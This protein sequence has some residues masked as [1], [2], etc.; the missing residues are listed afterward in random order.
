MSKS[1]FFNLALKRGANWTV[2]RLSIQGFIAQIIIG[3]ACSVVALAITLVFRELMENTL[4]LM[5]LFTIVV[6]S[7]LGGMI[8]G[9]ASSLISVFLIDYSALNPE[10]NLVQSILFLL[11]AV[12][13]SWMQDRRL[14]AEQLSKSLIEQRDAILESV[15]DGITA[16][17]PNGEVVF[18]NQA[19]AVIAGYAN[20]TDILEPIEQMQ[21]RYEM[22]DLN[23]SPLSFSALP[24]NTVFKEGKS[25]ELIFRAKM[26]ATGEERWIHTRSAPVVDGAGNVKLCV[27]VLRD[28]TRQRIAERSLIDMS[29]LLLEQNQRIEN[30][31]A[32]LPGI[33]WEGTGE[34]DGTQ[35]VEF[36]N[37]Y[38]E[39]VLGYTPE[40]WRTLPDFW[41]RVTHP[42]DW[43]IAVQRATEI[44]TRGIA[45]SMQ[46]RFVA[47]NGHT[48]HVETHTS[49]EH[50]SDGPSAVY[51][52]I[53][54]ISE[55]KQYEEALAEYS[56]NLRR[57]NEELEQ[58]AYVASHDLQEPLRMVTSYLQLIEGRYGDKFDPEGLEFLHF[59]VD[60]AARMKVLITDLLMYS[61]VQRKRDDF[62]TVALERVLDRALANLE[63]SIED[64][65][66]Q[67]T[68]AA[69]PTL[70]GNQGQLI[71][72][73]QNLISNAIKFRRDKPPVV[74]IGAKRL[75]REWEFFVEDNGIGIDQQYIERLFVIFQRLHTKDQYP[76]T[77]IGLAICKKVVENHRGRIWVESTPDQ[78]TTFYFTL[79][80]GDGVGL[81]D[82]TNDG[83][84]D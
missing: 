78:G 21:Q 67:V 28:I 44:F 68:S 43:D 62:K 49:I 29:S 83:N 25:S 23:G 59:A 5:F 46:M 27:N 1:T 39:R 8:S 63:L 2:S 22:F 54:D 37:D 40:E 75:R 31:I 77:G 76:G 69:L 55:R 79:P 52:V 47:K 4:F 33:L 72:L 66:A 71:Q 19:A 60:G 61:R 56:A 41:H 10:I 64:A 14:H 13:I 84:S 70:Y 51:G 35:R 11:V 12:I 58:F 6:A 65:G 9:L 81:E 15:A 73:F 20:T 45:G 17:L 16:Q 24:R 57:S 18:A 34:P 53:M 74:R 82:D 26:L 50:K 38:A 42:D 3:A 32:N 48:V 7:Y 80:L 36:V 30:M